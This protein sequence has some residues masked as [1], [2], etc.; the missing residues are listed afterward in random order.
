MARQGVTTVEHGQFDLRRK[1][2]KKPFSIIRITIVSQDSRD[3][4]YAFE[5]GVAVLMVIIIVII[6]IVI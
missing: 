1:A 4:R 2:N 6:I 3:Y 5:Y